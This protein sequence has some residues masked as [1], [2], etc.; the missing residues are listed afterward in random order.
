VRLV[1][2]ASTLVAELLRQRGRRLLAHPGL[3]V[4]VA[5]Q[6]WS[7]A[8]HEL[9]RRA[10]LMEQ[11]G[12]VSEATRRALL[13]SA[14]QVVALSVSQVPTAV[15]AHLQAIARARVPRD[16]KDWPTV[17]LALALGAGIWTGDND[18]LGCGIATWTTETLL[19]Q[20]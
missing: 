18:F 4:F 7:E 12:R 15:Y 19:E 9:H 2:D 10:Q 14:L 1:V 16:P 6:A 5:E 13:E 11:R 8:R 17:E 3:E 20:V